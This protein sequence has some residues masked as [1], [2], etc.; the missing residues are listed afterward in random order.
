MALRQLAEASM[1]DD[2]QRLYFGCGNLA[3]GR[4][5]IMYSVKQRNGSWGPATPVD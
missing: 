5:S 1:P 4:V 3:T 2:G